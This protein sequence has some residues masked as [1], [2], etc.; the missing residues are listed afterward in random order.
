MSACLS[1]PGVELQCV[2][3][4]VSSPSLEAC[5]PPDAVHVSV[6]AGLLVGL[7][8]EVVRPDFCLRKLLLVAAGRKA[9]G[10]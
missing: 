3:A 10:W 1:A 7:F 6:E 2:C 5:K 4:V 9:W 8:W